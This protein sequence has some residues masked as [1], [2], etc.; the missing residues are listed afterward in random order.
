M[1]HVCFATFV[2]GRT[3]GKEEGRKDKRERLLE[4]FL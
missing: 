4:V 1:L 3:R 2:I